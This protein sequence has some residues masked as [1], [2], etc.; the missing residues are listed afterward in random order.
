MSPVARSSTRNAAL[1]E[2]WFVAGGDPARPE[3]RIDTHADHGARVKHR[4]AT[5]SNRRCRRAL[6]TRTTGAAGRASILAAP[7]ALKSP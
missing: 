5:P 4:H 2:R 6:T 1:P 3:V 7:A